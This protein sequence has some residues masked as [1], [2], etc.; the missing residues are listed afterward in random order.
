MLDRA[1]RPKPLSPPSNVVT[2]DAASLWR[3][4]EHAAGDP[5]VELAR[6][7]HLTAL[8]ERLVAR[9]AEMMFNAALARLQPKLP[10]LDERGAITGRDGEIVA[11]YATWEDTVAAIR[12]IL[13]R[14]GFSLTFRP[15]RSAKGVPTVTGV[16]RHKVGH[17]EEAELELPAD[18]TGEKNAVQAV[19]STMSYGQRYVAKLL[20]NLTSRGEDDD[21]RAAGQ[22]A[23][24]FAAIAEI[25]ALEGKP[26]FLAWKRE[27]R[28]MLGKLEP[29]VFQRV[30]GHYGARLRRQAGA[31]L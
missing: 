17:K 8:H 16:L 4:I 18:T 22:S 25:N 26:A 2:V 6:L 19:G 5:C 10:E 9:G 15:G 28:A 27:R 30:I 14:H 24:E 13:A 3:V 1:S 11:T 7:D 21:G 20:L 31:A 29:A 12:P 23:A